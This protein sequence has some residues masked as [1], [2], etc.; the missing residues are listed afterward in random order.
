MS[1]SNP[2]YRILPAHAETVGLLARTDWAATPLGPVEDWPPA[3]RIALGICMNS[4]F[5]MFLWWGERYINFYNDAYAPILGRRHPA[6]FGQPA[7]EVWSEI[8]D[9]VGRQADAVMTRGEATWNERVLLVMERNGF[10]EETYFTWS[11]SPVPDGAGGVAG[12]FCAC[13]ED[14]GRVRIERERDR[15]LDDLAYE[16]SQLAD[17]FARS[18]V[19]MALVRTPDYVFEYVNDRYVELI[20]G[21]DP[22]GSTVLEAVPEVAQQGFI[23]LLDRVVATGE[24]VTGQAVPVRLRRGPGGAM[25]T[26]Y[27]DFIY[28]PMFAPDGSVNGVLG[29]GIDVTERRRAEARDRFVVELD[30]AV[31]ALTDAD[32]I[33]RTCARL[34][35]EHLDADRCAY[36]DVEDDQDTFNL[37]GDYNRG[38]P[39]IVGRYTFAAF[40][41]EALEC[42]RSGRVFRIDDID[43]HAPRPADLAAYRRTCIQAVVCVPV[44]K[45]GR[46]VAAMA[47]HQARPRV[48]TDD[49]VELVVHTAH[50][51]WE[52]IQRA[53][54]ERELR[55]SE[56]RF[57]VAVDAMSDIVWSCTPDG[58][59][60][61]E[62]PGW[63]AFTGQSF[64][65][66]RGHGW[67]A[68]VH[69]DDAA[70]SLAQWRAAVARGE[71]L[72]MQHRLR[73]ADGVYR[74]CSVRVAP[75]LDADGAVREWVGVHTDISERV[76]FEHSLQESEARFRMMSDRA[77]VMIWVTRPDGYCE[78]LNQ[79]WF[80]FTGQR[81]DD[82]LGHGWL[83]AVHPED[84][85]GARE[86]FER[87]N[88]ARTAFSMEYRL[89]RTDGVY[90]WC[91]DTASPRFGAGGAFLGF[92]GSVIDIT[93]RKQVEEA[94]A[95]EKRVLELIATGSPL[96]DVLDTL[97]RRL[98]SQSPDGVLCSILLVSEDGTRLV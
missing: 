81:P 4:R 55:R 76:A 6:A 56:R 90:R 75:V 89:R 72:A 1:E 13:T 23:E 49:E 77:P 48:W 22:T 57:R 11:Y 67:M 41:D 24:P 96:P 42:M 25:D 71:L 85:P 64:D 30:E 12:V 46:F 92:I 20:G 87:S 86:V 84:T 54:V 83:D 27:M 80:E 3:L 82:A 69:P 53:R 10:P 63:A 16:R 5:P 31:R 94:L 7:Q 88:V 45:G 93:E 52:S 28:Q 68:A 62:Q 33:T 43:R 9:V 26:R 15:L 44:L 29:H 59:F 97:A 34:L 14:T 37:T 58:E 21:R 17:V 39:S 73:R 91:V 47:V 98:E 61:S 35:G 32:E 36:A 51:C 74:V 8:W 19:C 2:L 70:R 65:Q 66:Y 95:A 78:Y 60:V 18:P 40:G 79:R 50:R 38:V